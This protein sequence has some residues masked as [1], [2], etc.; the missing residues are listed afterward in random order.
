[1]LLETGKKKPLREAM[2]AAFDQ[3]GLEMFVED[4]FTKKLET[5]IAVNN[6]LEIQC[7][8]L[9]GWAERA[10]LVIPLLLAFQNHPN[11]GLKTLAGELLAL[12]A[13]GAAVPGALA[14]NFVV[15]ARPI[16]N[17]TDFWKR[18]SAIAGGA[19]ANVLIVH[20]GVGKS[21]SVWPMSHFCNPESPVAKFALVRANQGTLVDGVGLAGLIATRLWGQGGL[22]EIDE[23]AQAQRAAKDLGTLLVQRLS[24]LAE[25]TWLVIDELN[26]ANIDESAIALLLSLC[27]AVDRGECPQL[28]LFLFGLDPAR[29]GQ[30]GRFIQAD[31]VRR[32]TR[33]DIEDYLTWFSGSIGRELDEVRLTGLV[34][35]L[36]GLLPE[37]PDHA[38]WEG[39]HDRL[40]QK[41]SDLERGVAP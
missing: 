20:G 31:Q 2:I 8:Q 32:P 27:D 12:S 41:C 16:L 37:A 5:L 7:H 40:Y 25:R 28:R 18:L 4:T 1:M 3:A 30:K 10:G 15:Q 29:L 22:A 9:I 35:E 36:D 14:R 19:G 26:L 6:T 38:S 34:D 23:F 17:R 24:T 11:L 21:Y 39:F 13:R 33:K